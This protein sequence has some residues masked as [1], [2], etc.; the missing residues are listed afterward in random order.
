M[1][2]FGRMPSNGIAGSYGKCFFF[3]ILT[4]KVVVPACIPTNSEGVFLFPISAVS[5]VRIVL[6]DDLVIL[7]G[8]R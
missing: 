4:F 3:S 5:V 2:F 1:Q 6:D 8:V 7:T